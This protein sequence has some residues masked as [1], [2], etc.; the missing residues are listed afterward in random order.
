MVFARFFYPEKLHT[1]TSNLDADFIN[2][3]TCRVSQ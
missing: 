2:T 3:G 1:G